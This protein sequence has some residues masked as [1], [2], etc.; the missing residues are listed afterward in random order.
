MIII[1]NVTLKKRDSWNAFSQQTKIILFSFP[2]QV[3]V[4]IGVTSNEGWSLSNFLFPKS[5]DPDLPLTYRNDF[6]PVTRKFLQ[7]IYG[8]DVVTFEEILAAVL[9]FNYGKSPAMLDDGI[10]LRRRWNE[11]V[12]D[13]HLMAPTTKLAQLLSGEIPNFSFADLAY[14]PIWFIGIL[15]TSSNHLLI[16][17]SL[18]LLGPPYTWHW[19]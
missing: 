12:G 6:I 7:D 4:M 11:L 3:P 18:Y 17:I 16:M 9:D 2:T 14:Y 13:L 1:D 15:L 5:V 19:L 10:F 8:T